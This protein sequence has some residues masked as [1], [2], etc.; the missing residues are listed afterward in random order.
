MFA[1]AGD[2]E[3]VPPNNDDAAPLLL[4]SLS[5]SHSGPPAPKPHAADRENATQ[6]NDDTATRHRT[7]NNTETVV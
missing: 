4:P 7:T 2:R 1:H 6:S 3:N 5:P